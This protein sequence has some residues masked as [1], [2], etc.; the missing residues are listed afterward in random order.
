MGQVVR[1]VNHDVTQHQHFNV[2]INHPV[3]DSACV[4]EE[5]HLHIYTQALTV[6]LTHHE[7]CC[8]T[9]DFHAVKEVDVLQFAIVLEGVQAA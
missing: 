8:P 6:S 5:A 9:F 3:P 1:D 4:G 2:T 7:I